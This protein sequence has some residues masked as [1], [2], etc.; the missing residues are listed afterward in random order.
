LLVGIGVERI[1]DIILLV[2]GV[3]SKTNKLREWTQ[4]RY[5]STHDPAAITP[6]TRWRDKLWELVVAVHLVVAED[7]HRNREEVTIGRE[8]CQ[9]LSKSRL[10]WL[11]AK[12]LLFAEFFLEFFCLKIFH[13]ATKQK[14]CGF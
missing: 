9:E 7:A 11:S 2:H 3:A 8:V 1:V 5:W 14:E 13:Q 12:S 10:S 4:V 6:S